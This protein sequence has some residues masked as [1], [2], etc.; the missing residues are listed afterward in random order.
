MNAVLLLIVNFE[1]ITDAPLKSEPAKG[2]STA[3]TAHSRYLGFLLEVD[4]FVDC[5]VKDW[6]IDWLIDYSF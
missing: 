6:L 4:W 2:L 3:S 1:N 5:F